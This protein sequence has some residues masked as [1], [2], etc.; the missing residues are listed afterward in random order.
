MRERLVRLAGFVGEETGAAPGA[1]EREARRLGL[2]RSDLVVRRHLVDMMRL[3]AAWLGPDDVPTEADLETYLAHHPDEFATPARIRLTHVYLNE[4]RHGPTATTDAAALLA[5]L[6]QTAPAAAASHGDPFIRGADIDATPPEL[7]RIF[8][9]G[10]TDAIA[11][12][13]IHTWFGPVGLN[14][15]ASTFSA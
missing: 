9:P 5:E 10:F 8:G 3:A 1:L 7:D 15:R 2:E 13:P 11:P 14:C 6:R 4:Q 12:A